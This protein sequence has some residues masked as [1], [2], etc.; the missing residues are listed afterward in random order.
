MNEFV[1]GLLSGVV[2]T[3]VGHPL[4]TIK[5]RLQCAKSNEKLSVATCVKGTFANE[6]V[7]GFYKGI[8]SPLMLIPLQN[9]IIFN[10]F[11][12]TKDYIRSVK[13]EL[14]TTNYLISGACAGTVLSFVTTPLEL[15]KIRSQMDRSVVNQSYKDVLNQGKKVIKTKGFMGLYKGYNITLI[16]EIAAFSAQFTV[17]ETVKNKIDTTIF[18]KKNDS[19]NDINL[20]SSMIAGGTSGVCCWIASYVPDILK[21]NIQQSEEKMS[22]R[23][24]FNNVVRQYGY[25][26]LF[27]GI[28]TCFMRVIIVDSLS[29]PVFEYSN[30]F[31]KKVRGQE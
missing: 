11:H 9:A 2:N 17:Y 25:R 20:A 4:D 22:I 14:V 8:T 12:Q 10:V 18:N 24:A 16:R 15:V 28:H 29:F 13:P 26:G 31:L 3:C 7:R 6:G 21:T 30:L 19:K 23:T 5:V 27:R 1:A